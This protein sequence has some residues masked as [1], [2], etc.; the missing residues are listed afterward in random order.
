MTTQAHTHAC[1][2]IQTQT[3]T[4]T[5]GMHCIH[6]CT[7]QSL[8][9]CSAVPQRP[10]TYHDTAAV[11]HSSPVPFS[12]HPLTCTAI[13]RHVTLSY[14]VVTV[15]MSCALAVK[16]AK[17]ELIL[18]CRHTVIQ[19]R[20]AHAA[21][22]IIPVAIYSLCLHLQS[23]SEIVLVPLQTQPSVFSAVRKPLWELAHITHRHLKRMDTYSV[24]S[25]E[26]AGKRLERKVMERCLSLLMCQ[27]GLI[28]IGYDQKGGARSFTCTSEDIYQSWAN[29]Y[30]TF[31]LYFISNKINMHQ[32]TS[33]YLI[34]LNGN[35]VS[36]IP[37]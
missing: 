14:V 7:Q 34:S 20:H 3:H 29:I 37:N 31:L 11:D 22:Q 27:F 21:N 9:C 6:T 24:Y 10:P 17:W 18:A 26:M 35:R 1:M 25:V 19:R 33:N 16:K 8:H 13:D 5:H 32:R 36:H 30:C 12:E 2:H 23:L 4:P 28:M 15:I